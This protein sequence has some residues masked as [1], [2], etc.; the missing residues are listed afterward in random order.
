MAQN[1]N[2]YIDAIHGECIKYLY[3]WVSTTIVAF[4]DLSNGQLRLSAHYIDRTKNIEILILCTNLP[5]T[6]RFLRI[7]NKS[8]LAPSLWIF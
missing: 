4:T 3:F 6:D 8:S 2:V 5:S 1:I 7:Y